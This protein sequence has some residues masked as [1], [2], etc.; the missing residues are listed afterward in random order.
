MFFTIKKLYN[1]I[2][3][4]KINNLKNILLIFI[5][6]LFEVLSIGILIP[7]IAII[8]KPEFFNEIN[9]FLSS[10]KLF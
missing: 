8:L 1:I 5:N 7:L 6:S 10:Q 4:S 2:K 3:F 9:F